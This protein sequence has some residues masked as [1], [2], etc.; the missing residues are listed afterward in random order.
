MIYDKKLSILLILLVNLFFFSS[1]TA[2]LFTS[3]L[4]DTLLW[5][6]PATWGGSKP[7]EGDLVV[8]PSETII[9]LDEAIPAF[10]G[11]TI[12]GTLIFAQMDLELNSDWILV[13][14]K[15]E[16]GTEEDP[17]THSAIFT[18]TGDDI[19]QSIM[20]M[21]TR[22]IMVMG[23]LELH[24]NP[25]STVWTKINESADIG[26]TS[27]TLMEPVNWNVGDEIVI[28]PT[29]Y[30]E[31]GNGI[32]VSQKIELTGVSGTDLAL[33]TGLNAHRWGALQ[34]PT[35]EGMSLSPENV[36]EAPIPDTD[37]ISTPLFLDERAP[38]GNLSRNIVIQSPDDELWQ[39]QGF[40][41][42]TMIMPSGSAK[43][44]GVEFRRG[45]QQGLIRRYTF[46]WH[47][48]SYFG[49]ETLE[50]ATGQYIINSTVNSS[51]NRGIVIHGTNGVLV[52]NNVLF[53]IRGHGVFTEDAVERRNTIDGNLVLHIR[54][55]PYELA[56][57]LHETG[58]RG[59]SA[60]W[61]SN[62]DNIITNNHVADSET[63][64]FWFA[65]PPNPW[66]D[67]QNT[68]AEDGLIMNPSRIRF[69]VFDNNTTHSNRVEG[70]MLD[71][72]E[73]DNDGTTLELQYE[74]T[75]NGRPPVW[76]F[77]TRR[78][79]QLTRYKTWKNGSSGIWDR[80]VWPDNF[81]VVSADNVG[82]FF[83]GSGADGVIERSLV[84]GTSLNYSMN[85]TGRREYTDILGNTE[86]PVAF[87]TYHS[88]FD[89][90]N[91]IVVNFPMVPNTRSGTFA[92]ED[93][94]IRPVDK[95]QVRNIGNILIDSHVG[96]KLMAPFNYFA[97]A[98]A[99]WDPNRNWGGTAENGYLVYDTP[100]FTYGQTPFQPE[101]GP[102]MGGVVVEGPFYG[103]NHFVLNRENLPWEDLMAISVD[104]LDD[105]F[106][107]VG[108]WD[109]NGIGSTTELLAHMR[110]FAAHPSSYYSLE[111]PDIDTV[112]DIA[113][114]IENML[115][116]QDTLVLAIEYS[117]DYEVGQVYSSSYSDF[118][119][120]V[121]AEWPTNFSLKHVFQPVES[122]QAVIDSEVEAYWQD[123]ENDIVWTKVFGGIG[124]PWNDQDYKETDDQRLYRL[125]NLRIY[126]S[127]LQTSNEE[128]DELPTE[129][130]LDQNYP[131]PFNPSTT[132]QFDVAE[133]SQISLQIF[134]MTGRLVETL[135]NEQKTAGSYSISWKADSQ[136]SG[137]YF[138]RMVS[139]AG[140]QTRKM[141]LMK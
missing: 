21:G 87:A 12:D 118:F 63:N 93:Y 35:L 91:N 86:A 133:T 34:Y 82:R 56:L 52:Q 92:T 74:S 48:L 18:L 137:V 125:F 45:G 90:K 19:E 24:G 33:G 47:I 4:S 36:V 84:V 57:K 62:P 9:L 14:G 1:A 107:E 75:T 25:P 128:D 68:L 101:P 85:G 69:G 44:N 96:V 103:F 73:I 40:G 79:F 7:I 60:F 88:A 94:Y 98:G 115:T 108:S 129:F 65:F 130:S 26:S 16:V 29:D 28:G 55:Q 49:A 11:L 106:N 20:G 37:S 17:F 112:S 54:N 71:R 8:I 97:L 43:V 123:H 58:E 138:L 42:H 120:Q 50:D 10:S 131:N 116:D 77:E 113:F 72:V 70:I 109:I 23:E 76:P 89:I 117:G 136:A 27:L 124:Q 30:Y 141:L 135:V 51:R 99:L 80:G 32:S 132:I 110:H 104:R 2:G 46:H 31:A 122:R 15:L 38:V 61:I 134:D 66:G 114:S 102:E 121:H 59:A 22:G 81:G 119:D 6:D 39:N 64:G 139:P 111:F 126:G 78:R 140:I 3:Q 83:A 53:D 41:V 67:H 5:S 13:N 100:F 105:Q 127:P 95:G